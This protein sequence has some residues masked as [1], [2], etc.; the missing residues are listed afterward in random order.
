MT[1]IPRRALGY[2]DAAEAS[3]ATFLGLRSEGVI[4]EDVRFQVSAPTP[5]ATVVAWAAPTTRSASSAFTRTRSPTRWPRSRRSST[6]GHL[7]IQYDVAV[8][9][10]VLTGSFEAAGKL[11]D[12]DVVL[13][14]LRDVFVRT[15]EGGERGIHLCY[16]DYR[17]RHFTVPEDLGLCVEMANAVGDLADFVHMPVDRESGRRSSY[18]EP[19][20]DLRAPG[21]LALGVIDYEGDG[22]RSRELAHAAAEGGGGREFRSRPSA[23]WRASTS[24]ARARRASRTCCACTRPS[25][26][27]SVRADYGTRARVKA[28]RPILRGP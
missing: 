10:G 12:K 5:Y 4:P 22:V 23:A 24:A 20:R 16:G 14:T 2:A 18:F 3:Y 11:A 27:P 1:A 13:E 28:R 26:R 17:H 25:P 15:P 21:R 9:V 8:E 7:A 19:L 6:R